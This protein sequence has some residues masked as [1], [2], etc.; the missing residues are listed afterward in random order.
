[1]YKLQIAF[2]MRMIKHGNNATTQIILIFVCTQT[3]CCQILYL[4]ISTCVICEH[5]SWAEYTQKMCFYY[6]VAKG[7]LEIH[8]TAILKKCTHLSIHLTLIHHYNNNLNKKNKSFVLLDLSIPK[9]FYYLI[10]VFPFSFS[11]FSFVA[12]TYRVDCRWK[13]PKNWKVSSGHFVRCDFIVVKVS[14][15]HFYTFVWFLCVWVSFFVRQMH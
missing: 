14:G 8:I 12:G 10:N 6:V 2:C 11:S 3:R 9:C 15:E 1:L 13:E 4:N 7:R 5:M